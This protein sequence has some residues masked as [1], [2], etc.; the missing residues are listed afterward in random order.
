VQKIDSKPTLADGLAVAEAG[1]LCFEIAR[2]V[3]DEVVL[4][5]E[6]QI[7]KSILRLLELEKMMVEGAGA[8]SLA[9]AIEQKEPL[10]GK[11]VVLCLTGGNIDVNTVGKIIER[12]LAADGRLCRIGARISDRPGELAR[13]ASVIAATG[14]SIKEIDHDRAFG[15]AD[16]ARVGVWCTLETRDFDHVR[17]I[18][19]ALSD[20]GIEVYATGLHRTVGGM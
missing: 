3:V 5:D 15:P 9:A 13:L 6:E 18:H 16:I 12:G 7:A 1:N 19:Q 14:A 2:Q 4:V 11:K 17:T 20:A 10:A 8:V